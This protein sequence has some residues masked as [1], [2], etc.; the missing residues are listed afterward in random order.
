MSIL[1][2]HMFPSI[3]NTVIITA[4][5]NGKGVIASRDIPEGD[6]I[7]IFERHYVSASTNKTLHIND[8][9]YQLSRN[10]EAA[11]NFINH[12]CEPNAYVDFQTIDL[13][14]LRNIHAGEEVTYDYCT[15][16]WDNE[17]IFDCNCGSNVC[18]KRISGF[19]NLDLE[20]RDRLLRYASP[21][22]QKRVVG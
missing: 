22:I 3:S 4:T 1:L 5:H 2:V 20:S 18:R 10:S 14:A 15:S 11:E 7:L 12:S 21:F 13:K 8:E 9:L 6:T 17:D 16:D 19:K